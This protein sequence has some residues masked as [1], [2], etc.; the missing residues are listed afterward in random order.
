MIQY[1]VSLRPVRRIVML[2]RYPLGTLSVFKYMQPQLCSSLTIRISFA[3]SLSRGSERIEQTSVSPIKRCRE[4]PSLHKS[5]PSRFHSLERLRNE[6]KTMSDTIYEQLY[7][8]GL[9]REMAEEV[10][11]HVFSLTGQQAAHDRGYLLSNGRY[12]KGRGRY[13]PLYDKICEELDNSKDLLVYGGSEYSYVFALREVEDEWWNNEFITAG[14]E[15]FNS[16]GCAD[17]LKRDS[18]GYDIPHRLGFLMSVSDETEQYVQAIVDFFKPVEEEEEEEEE[19]ED[20][21]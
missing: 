11:S 5:Y 4:S 19:E 10:M 1:I 18:L 13:Q 20:E 2:D 9:F 17:D 21:S 6:K 15:L 8:N 7:L 3:T 14:K 12:L 16:D